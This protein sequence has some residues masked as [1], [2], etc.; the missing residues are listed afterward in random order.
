MLN[1]PDEELQKVD[2][3]HL[4]ADKQNQLLEIFY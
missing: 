3:V 1:H 4:D 2:S